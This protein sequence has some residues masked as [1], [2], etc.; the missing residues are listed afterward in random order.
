[1]HDKNKNFCITFAGAVGSSKTPIA[2]HLSY[3]YNIPI[4]NNDTIRT[5][6]IEDFLTFNT[7]EYINRRD[8]RAK[9]IFE[10]GDSYIY[11]AGVDREWGKYREIVANY[12]YDWF[13]ISMDLTKE[14]LTKLY[15]AKGYLE[16][17][18][19]I[20]KIVEDH[21]NFLKEFD[22]DISLHITD[23]TFPDRLDL[24]SKAFKA[25]Y[26]S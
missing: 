20:D 5:E 13:I 11:D 18:E 9:E 14:F 7:E 6:V 19:R 22:K 15:K 3:T 1:M 21:N 24:S 25:W 26:Q 23:K 8:S 10:R 12:N 17:L 16:S 2:Y 4:F